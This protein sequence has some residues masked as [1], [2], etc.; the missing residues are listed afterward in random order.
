L[1]RHICSHSIKDLANTNDAKKKASFSASNLHKEEMPVLKISDAK[2]KIII[3]EKLQICIDTLNFI[4][5]PQ[6]IM[7]IATGQIE[8]QTCITRRFSPFFRENKL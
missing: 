1:S 2:D 4:D 7:N 5:H 6:N 3:S 8:V